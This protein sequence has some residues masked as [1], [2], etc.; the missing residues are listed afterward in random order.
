MRHHQPA[1]THSRVWGMLRLAGVVL[2]A[3]PLVLMLGTGIVG[4]VLSGQPCMDV[5][6]PAELL[7]LT[8]PGMILVAAAAVR[9]RV[10]V[11]LAVA[12]PV[13]AFTALALCQGLALPTALRTPLL[14]ALLL[15]FDFCAAAT[16]VLGIVSARRLRRIAP[17]NRKDTQ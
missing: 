14:M 1:P 8:L 17:Q 13:V 11:R 6:L 2:F 3:A 7:F 15:V 4:S 10:H 12:L 9:Q 16:P 5:F